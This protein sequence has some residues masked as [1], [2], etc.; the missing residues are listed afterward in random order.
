MVYLWLGHVGRCAQ[1]GGKL[2]AWLADGSFYVLGYS[3]WWCVLLGARAWLSAL[4]RW[5]RD[6]TDSGVRHQNHGQDARPHALLGLSPR[7]VFWLGFV[8]LVIASCVLEWSRLYRFEP[9]LPGHAGGVLGFVA[10]G[11]MVKWLGFTGSALVCIAAVVAGSGLGVWL[12]VGA[13]GRWSGCLGV[14]PVGAA[15]RKT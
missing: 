12:F 5:L 11:F 7:A 10:G 4:S 8:L 15:P 1:L 2:G 13:L 6:N 14:Q 9:R 3:V